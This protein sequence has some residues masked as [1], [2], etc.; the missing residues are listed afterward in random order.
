[1][2][3][4]AH[5]QIMLSPLLPQITSGFPILFDGRLQNETNK[6]G[7]EHV[8]DQRKLM[9]ITRALTVGPATT[10]RSEYD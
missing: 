10:A 1:M 4:F 7:H 6:E 2:T 5:H 9:N 8:K 3:V